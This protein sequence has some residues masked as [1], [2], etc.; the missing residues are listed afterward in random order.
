MPNDT[1][2]L[3]AELENIPRGGREVCGECKEIL[4]RAAAALRLQ[5]Q[6]LATEEKE[7]RE[8]VVTIATLRAQLAEAN[9]A[10]NWL[11]DTP[12]IGLPP[13]WLPDN[14]SCGKSGEQ[15]F[16]HHGDDEFV[17]GDTAVQAIESFR[18]KLAALKGETNE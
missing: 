14:W 3:I 17:Y 18:A 1:D 6:E 5:A 16:L 11:F 10:I 12:F 2:K 8:D 4:Q 13:E 9:A 7:H 15:Y